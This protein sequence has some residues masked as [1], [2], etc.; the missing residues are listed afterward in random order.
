MLGSVGSVIGLVLIL[1]AVAIAL[2]IGLVVRVFR[3]PPRRRR[4]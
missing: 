3:G 2:V 1:I 4:W